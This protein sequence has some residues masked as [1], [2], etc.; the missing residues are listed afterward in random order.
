MK[1]ALKANGILIVAALMWSVGGLF[2][3]LVELSP[4]AITG[5]R[6]LAA[7]GVFLIYLQKLS[8]TGISILSSE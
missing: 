5:T 2:I 8:G 6:S 7:A 4:L 1:A 3:K